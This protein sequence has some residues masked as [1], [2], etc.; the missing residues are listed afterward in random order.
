MDR[1][2]EQLPKTWDNPI[3][4]YTPEQMLKFHEIVERELQSR[5]ATLYEQEYRCEFIPDPDGS[6]TVRRN[7]DEVVDVSEFVSRSLP[8]VRATAE[9]PISAGDPVIQTSPRMHLVAVNWSIEESDANYTLKFQFRLP[10][11]RQILTGKTTMD[12]A[13]FAQLREIF[14]NW[15]GEYYATVDSELN[16]KIIN[17]DDVVIGQTHLDEFGVEGERAG[18]I[19]RVDPANILASP[20]VRGIA[21]TPRNLE[22]TAI[23]PLTIMNEVLGTYNRSSNGDIVYGESMVAPLRK[24]KYPEMTCA[25]CEEHI[26]EPENLREFLGPRQTRK[27]LEFCKQT[28]QKPMLYCCDCFDFIEKHPKILEEYTRM[29]EAYHTFRK[30]E[31]E[32]RKSLK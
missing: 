11:G 26:H 31:S 19:H 8:A 2:P 4:N 22:G 17:S 24:Q 6:D 1:I 27:Y 23:T 25:L 18:V 29:M 13:T 9:E 12:N 28:D 7:I 16:V 5:E 3:K 30:A 14:N 15:P 32:A 10:D 20:H 21:R